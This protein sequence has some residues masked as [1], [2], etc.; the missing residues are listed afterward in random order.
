MVRLYYCYGCTFYNKILIL[1]QVNF[2]VKYSTKTNVDDFLITN[3]LQ[4][5][6]N[7]SFSFKCISNYFTYSFQ[8]P[9]HV[10]RKTFMPMGKMNIQMPY[11]SGFSFQ[12]QSLTSASYNH[13]LTRAISDGSG[14]WFPPPV[15]RDELSSSLPLSVSV[16][17]ELF[18]GLWEVNGR[19]EHESPT[20]AFLFIISC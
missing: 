2:S 1:E 11:V 6:F 14:H 15:R 20:Y 10:W 19:L 3:I 18:V 5:I 8:T 9:K 16:Q 12:P 4:T 7:K 17:P 13:P